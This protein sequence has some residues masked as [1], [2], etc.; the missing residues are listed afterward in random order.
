MYYTY[1]YYVKT[2]YGLAKGTLTKEFVRT[3]TIEENVKNQRHDSTFVMV[4]GK[5]VF[6]RNGFTKKIQKDEYVR[7]V[8]TDKKDQIT[9]AVTVP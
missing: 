7:G 8:I 5:A 1:P 6:V 3:V 4:Q 9:N 2:R